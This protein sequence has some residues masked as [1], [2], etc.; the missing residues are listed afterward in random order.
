MKPIIA[1]SLGDPAGIGPEIT[2]ACLPE[3]I[4]FCTPVLFGH[5]PTFEARCHSLCQP[6][7]NFFITNTIAGDSISKTDS[8][9]PFVNIAGPNH[10]IAHPGDDAAKIQLD[11]LAAAVTAVQNGSCHAIVTAPVSKKL[12]A[13][14]EPDFTG[15]TEYLAKRCGLGKDDVT[16]VFASKKLVVGLISTHISLAKI[17][18]TI[19]HKRYLRTLQHVIETVQQN[20]E[21][22]NPGIT[23][24]VAALNPHGGENGLIGREEID[25]LYPFCKRQNGF[26]GAQ[27][28]GPIPADAIF[29]DAFAGKY[30]GVIAAYHDQALIPLKLHGFGGATNVTAGLPFVRTSPDHGTAYELAG[31]NIADAGAMK[32]AIEMAVHLT[33]K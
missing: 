2:A 12:I 30:H 18:E 27:I 32:A 10:V 25:F 22:P 1:I 29:R 33:R 17:P 23:V 20:T 15:H 26:M 11:A 7:D 8:H 13:R 5:W 16:M 14:I 19:T 28:H 21:A 6:V 4:K 31:K 9:I 3:S 24:A